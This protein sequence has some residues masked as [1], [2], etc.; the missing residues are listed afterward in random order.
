M[1][2]SVTLM[3]L[4]EVP[5][6]LG[7]TPPILGMLVGTTAADAVLLVV[8]VAVDGG[9]RVAVG[10]GGCGCGAAGGDFDTVD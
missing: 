9:G 6:L 5:L 3:P 4:I 1:A 10:G 8:G 2:S 7:L